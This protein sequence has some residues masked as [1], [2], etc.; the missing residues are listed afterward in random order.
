MAIADAWTLQEAIYSAVSGAVS[1]EGITVVDHVLHDPPMEHVRI[2]GMEYADQSP[3][4]GERGRH[5]FVISYYLRPTGDATTYVGLQ[6]VW[7][8]LGMVH[9]AVKD[10][11][12]NNH[13]PRQRYMDATSDNDGHTQHGM[14]RYTIDL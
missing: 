8:V 7:A 5:S 9:A 12:V 13:K 10:V 14:I 6:R 4:N 1:G 3:K 2:E 11:T